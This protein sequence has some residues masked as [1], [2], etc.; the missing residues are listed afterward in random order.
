MFINYPRIELKL[1]GK[2]YVFINLDRMETIVQEPIN[3]NYEF[4]ATRKKG[5][6][7]DYFDYIPFSGSAP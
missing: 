4:P 7:T 6:I 2:K 1:P 5:K 3:P